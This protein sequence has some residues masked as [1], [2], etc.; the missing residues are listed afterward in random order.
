M[1]KVP[2]RIFAAWIFS[3]SIFASWM[4]A[5]WM[6]AAAALAC[7]P[8]ACA[9]AAYNAGTLAQANAALQAGEADKT[10]DLIQSLPQ[11][12][13]GDAEAE[14]LLCRTEF[15]IGEWDAAIRACEQ[16]IRLDPSS[17]AGHL[18][19]GRA[20]GEKASQTSFL[21]AF[22]LGKRVLVEFHKAADLDPRNGE[23]LSDLGEFYLEAPALLGGGLD[24]ADSVA[25]ELDRVEPVRAAELRAGIASRRGD[26]AG[27]EADLKRAL[28]LSRHPARQWATMARFYAARGQ[29]SDMDNAVHNCQAAVARDPGAAVA[30]YDAAGVLTRARRDPELAVSLL[31]RYLASPR[32]S[33]E[34]PAFVAYARLARLQN[35]LGD[36]VNAREAMA[37][38]YGLAREYQPG[39][40]LRR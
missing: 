28:A 4:A 39:Q 30:L 19:L 23:A 16:A 2:L 26:Y 27:A 14:N 24:R 13:S 31:E 6:V 7:A 37:A 29:W 35:Q 22:S 36:A 8:L 5:I 17:S 34:A 15:T 32:K 12:G 11:G 40:D 1:A 18:W 33:E 38:A 9:A 25:Q 10:L 20:L 3:G 21:T